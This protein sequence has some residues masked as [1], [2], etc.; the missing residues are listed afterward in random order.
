M[1]S[2]YCR[3]CW[4]LMWCHSNSW[5]QPSWAFCEHKQ[6]QR[7]KT[8]GCDLTCSRTFLQASL[9]SWSVWTSSPTFSFTFSA[10]FS[11]NCSKTNK[12]TSTTPIHTCS[13]PSTHTVTSDLVVLLEHSHDVIVEAGLKHRP[14]QVHGN[15]RISVTTNTHAQARART[16]THTHTVSHTRFSQS[17]E[18]QRVIR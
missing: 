12:R 11:K 16:H 14:Q 10:A 18:S 2:K 17:Q 3:T 6:G 4:H 5:F 7:T 13:H 9:I 8:T 1:R 15:L